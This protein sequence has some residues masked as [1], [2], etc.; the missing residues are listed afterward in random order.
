MQL[1]R[2]F[3]LTHRSS[4]EQVALFAW[5][6]GLHPQVHQYLVKRL[7]LFSSCLPSLHV[8]QTE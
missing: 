8:E 7:H 3:E 2:N 6:V 5:A 4:P 1:E